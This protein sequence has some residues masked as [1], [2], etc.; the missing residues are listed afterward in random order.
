M[1]KK[2]NV[3]T[4]K[5]I[6]N[7]IKTPIIG[8]IFNIRLSTNQIYTCL[9]GGARVEEILNDGTKLTLGISNYNKENNPVVD[10]AALKV[11][12]EA[13]KKAEAE[14]LAAEAAAK[15]AEEKAKREAEEKAKR[16]EEERIKKEAELKAKEEAAKKAEAERLAAEAAAKEAEKV[17]EEIKAEDNTNVTSEHEDKENKEDVNPNHKNSGKRK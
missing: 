4:T 2:V 17:K 10:N 6:Y 1:V 14:R 11:K 15:E 7:V 5:T 9:A 12:E 8:T 16:E 3:F 13:A